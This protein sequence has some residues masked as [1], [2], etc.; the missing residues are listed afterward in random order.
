MTHGGIVVQYTY[1]GEAADRAG[2]RAGSRVKSI[3]N[4]DYYGAPMTF[5]WTLGGD[6]IVAIDGKPITTVDAVES[7]GQQGAGQHTETDSA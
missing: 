2:L 6:V 3:R 4:T 7:P 5:R 1:P